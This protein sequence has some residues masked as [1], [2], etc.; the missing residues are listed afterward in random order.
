MMITAT[1][2]TTPQNKI[3]SMPLTAG[4]VRLPPLPSVVAY[5]AFNSAIRS[6]AAER[7][8]SA[9]ASLNSG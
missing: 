7:S 5:F 3:Q 1:A 9:S 2:P 4:L 6:I 8:S